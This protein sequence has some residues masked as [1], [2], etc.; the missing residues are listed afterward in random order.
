MHGLLY[1]SLCCGYPQTMHEYLR[2]MENTLL[3]V[4]GFI[5]YNAS[6]LCECYTML[7]KC[8]CVCGC[9]HVCKFAH[10]I[11]ALLDTQELYILE[12]GFI[13]ISKYYHSQEPSTPPYLFIQVAVVAAAAALFRPTAIWTSKVKPFSY[14][15]LISAKNFC[16]YQNVEH[17]HIIM[18]LGSKSA[19]NMFVIGSK[20][21]W[22]VLPFIIIIIF[23]LVVFRPQRWQKP[24]TLYKMHFME[25]LSQVSIYV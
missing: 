3:Y 18:C 22:L 25:N 8:V 11:D 17:T 23:S 16:K 15:D 5:A 6:L 10:D 21:F 7:V 19:C 1:C 20:I 12:Y 2:I 24:C 9:I 13:R 14:I 4:L